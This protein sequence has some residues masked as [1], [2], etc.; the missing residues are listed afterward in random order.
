MDIIAA[1]NVVAVDEDLGHGFS[2]AGAIG[3][4][5][6]ACFV[7]VEVVLG[8]LDPFAIEEFFGLDAE[9]AGGPDVDFDVWGHSRGGGVFT[10]LYQFYS[11]QPL[12]A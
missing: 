1:A 4:F 8:V 2:A 12:V 3:H 5:A 6:A 7:P 11:P 9:G 10:K